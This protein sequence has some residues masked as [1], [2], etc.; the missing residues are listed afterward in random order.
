MN[1]WRDGWRER[2]QREL[3]EREGKDPTTALTTQVNNLS[4][5]KTEKNE[6]PA[7]S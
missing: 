7:F 3:E 5:L 2:Q 6:P 4:L 1:S